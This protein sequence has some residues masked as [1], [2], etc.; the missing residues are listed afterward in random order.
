MTKHK[1][2]SDVAHWGIRALLNIAGILAGQESAVRAGAPAAI[3]AAMTKHKDVADVAHYGCRALCHIAFIT[4]GQESAVHAGAP[5]AIVVAL[6]RFSDNEDVCTRASGA[7][8]N[9]SL[10]ELKV[11]DTNG[12]PMRVAIFT[13]AGAVPLLV[14]AMR[15]FNKDETRGALATLGFSPDGAKI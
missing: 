6:R 3:V 1:D 14:D 10:K 2:V 12:D 13:A 5:A 15:K 9:L 11:G 8:W 7:L 4:A